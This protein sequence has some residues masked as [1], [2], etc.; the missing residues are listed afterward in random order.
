DAR[1]AH[2]AE[3]RLMQGHAVNDGYS[4]PQKSARFEHPEFARRTCVGRLSL[5][6]VHD[7]G[8]QCAAVEC[9]GDVADLGLR[10][11][12]RENLVAQL[13]DVARL[14]RIRRI[15][16]RIEVEVSRQSLDTL[17]LVGFQVPLIETAD[18]RSCAAN[19]RLHFGKLLGVARQTFVENLAFGSGQDDFVFR[20]R[21]PL[22]AVGEFAVRLPPRQEVPGQ[23]VVQINQAGVN[24]AARINDLGS[25][26]DGNAFA[27]VLD[28]VAGNQDGPVRDDLHRRH[29]R[30]AQRILLFLGPRC[31]ASQGH[32][33]QERS[34]AGLSV[35]RS[36]LELQWKAALCHSAGGSTPKLVAGPQNEV[37]S[38]PTFGG[39]YETYGYRNS[40]AGIRKRCRRAVRGPGHQQS[41]RQYG[42]NARRAS[43][44]EPDRRRR[45]NARRQVQLPS[46]GGADELRPP[47]GARRGSQ[48]R[49]VRARCRRTAARDEAE[50]K[51]FQR[52]AEQSGQ[53]LVRVLR[54]DAGQG[55]RF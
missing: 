45:R 46:H 47:D 50:R 4:G 13:L 38:S 20:K 3:L 17:L 19:D 28:L 27:K 6:K 53:G 8:G 36:H 10:K 37:C 29:Q 21:L 39:R 16:S 55:R 9:F 25:G 33:E 26:G 32:S 1:V 40:A 44:E 7:E 24:E 15:E 31:Q 5:R 11:L 23:V 48:Q 34:E 42:A 30:P 43:V 12:Q 51:R 52:R 18:H 35:E 14:R 49:Y 2:L 41:C 54:T 22:V